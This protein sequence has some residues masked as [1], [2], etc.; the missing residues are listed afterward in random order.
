[1]ATEISTLRRGVEHRVVGGARRDQRP[2]AVGRVDLRT[3]QE[4]RHRSRYHSRPL[5]GVRDVVR[6]SLDGRRRRIPKASATPVNGGLSSRATWRTPLPSKNRSC[7]CRTR[8]SMRLSSTT[9]RT[10][11]SQRRR[12]ASS[13]TFIRMDPSPLTQIHGGGP[14]RAS[15]WRRSPPAGRTHGPQAAGGQVPARDD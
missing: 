7:H 9:S 13:W 15:A 3:W 4:D 10:G 6:R 12:V 11:R 14:G 5:D 2:G 1:M 8:P